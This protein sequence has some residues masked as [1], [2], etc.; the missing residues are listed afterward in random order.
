MFCYF[1]QFFASFSFSF[2]TSQPFE[3]GLGNI[4]ET[5][6]LSLALLAKLYCLQL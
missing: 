6:Q 3:M 5:N 1:M 4:Q 2:Y